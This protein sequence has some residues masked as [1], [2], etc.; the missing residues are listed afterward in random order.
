[1]VETMT[2]VIGADGRM[3]DAWDLIKLG[4]YEEAIAACTIDLAAR[5]DGGALGTRARAHLLAGQLAE[6]RSDILAVQALDPPPSKPDGFYSVTAFGRLGVIDWL[7]GDHA[8]AAQHWLTAVSALRRNRVDRK[9]PARNG[10]IGSLLMFAAARL[11]DASH[12][13][14][15]LALFKKTLKLRRIGAWPAPVMEFYVGTRTQKEML[16]CAAPVPILRERELCQG[17]FA[18]AV[19]RLLARDTLGFNE[20]MRKA[21]ATEATL[22]DEFFLARHEVGA[23]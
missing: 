20:Y 2:F 13:R 22:E 21:A 9:D 7:A 17:Y 8:A 1:M 23:A 15:A 11:D 18:I 5:T 6:A 19:S 16:A 4:R 14:A 10:M 3:A 12:L